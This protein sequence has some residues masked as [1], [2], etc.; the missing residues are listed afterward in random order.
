MA[1]QGIRV[2]T[3]ESYI[4][5]MDPEADY[6]GQHY[7]MSKKVPDIA[8]VPHLRSSELRAR[9]ER[10]YEERRLQAWRDY[11]QEQGKDWPYE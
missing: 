1:T 8:D 2:G 3:G 11:Y 7:R 6:F 4:D 9:A 10:Q 5:P